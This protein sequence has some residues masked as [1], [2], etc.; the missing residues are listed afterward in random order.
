MTFAITW[1]GSNGSPGEATVATHS[2]AL[3]VMNALRSRFPQVELW[4][5]KT[6]RVGIVQ[7][8]GK[9]LRGVTHHPMPIANGYQCAKCNP[10]TFMDGPKSYAS[11]MRYL[12]G[13][14]VTP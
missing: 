1:T 5:L 11:H 6:A 4:E 10:M 3:E 2:E 14:E 8:A 9:L 13:I 12:H 7:D